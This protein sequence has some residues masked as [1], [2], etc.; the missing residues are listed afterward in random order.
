M[1]I[2]FIKNLKKKLT[3]GVVNIVKCYLITITSDIQNALPIFRFIFKIIT[4]R[5]L[6]NLLDKIL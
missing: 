1:F 3:F 4:V 2:E 6:I 5:N